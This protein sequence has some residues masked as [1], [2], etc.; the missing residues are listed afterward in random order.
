[1]HRQPIYSN[2]FWK[3]GLFIQLIG[4]QVFEGSYNDTQSYCS[5][6]WCIPHG[7]MKIQPNHEFS[8]IAYEQIVSFYIR[9]ISLTTCLIIG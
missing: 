5:R 2:S 1:M 3:T 4:R 6:Q 7:L 9:P 8:C